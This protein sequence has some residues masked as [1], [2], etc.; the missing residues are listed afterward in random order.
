MAIARLDSV[1]ERL[2]PHCQASGATAD[3]A[4]EVTTTGDHGL[5]SVVWVDANDPIHSIDHDDFVV[6][7]D[8]Y[9]EMIDE[10]LTAGDFRHR[11]RRWMKTKQFPLRTI[12]IIDNQDVAR[13]F[14]RDAVVDRTRR[15]SLG[16]D[17]ADTLGDPM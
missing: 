17:A 13:A 16:Q 4:G 1:A 6:T 11:G 12:W 5:R 8:R 14:Y 7:L 2:L 9:S 3:G 15:L 10:F